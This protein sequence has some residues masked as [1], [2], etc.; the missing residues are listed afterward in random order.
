MYP[1]KSTCDCEG[2]ECIL[3]KNKK[4]YHVKKYILVEWERRKDRSRAVVD[5]GT[6]VWGE[7]GARHKREREREAFAGGGA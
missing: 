6:G 3:R 7:E 5:V 2:V 1:M 4:R